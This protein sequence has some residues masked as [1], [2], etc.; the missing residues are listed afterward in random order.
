MHL[1]EQKCTY[2]CSEWCMVGYGTGALLDLWDW[3]IVP[4]VLTLLEFPPRNGTLVMVTSSNGNIFPVTDP[5]EGNP[6]VTGGLPGHRWIPAQMPVTKGTLILSLIC[7]WTN[8][9]ANNWDAADLRRHRAHFDVNVMWK[10]HSRN[11]G[12][13]MP[14]MPRSPG[15]NMGLPLWR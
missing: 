11:H 1:S 5:C 4:V 13:V 9:S 6:P 15:L 12:N 3:S 8:G 14:L 10:I 2:F 7:T